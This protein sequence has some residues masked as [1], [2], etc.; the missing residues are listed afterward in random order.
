MN[1]TK[2]N[3]DL[4]I[5]DYLECVNNDYDTRVLVVANLAAS[6]EVSVPTIRGI[7]VT[8][9]VYKAKEKTTSETTSNKKEEIVKAL[10]AISGESLQSFNKATKK[11]LEAFWGYVVK[12]TDRHDANAV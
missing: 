9:K 10:E 1:L 8:A 7:L 2:E 11:D 6:F 3:K 5:S 4:I 12:A